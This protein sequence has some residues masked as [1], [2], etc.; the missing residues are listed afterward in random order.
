MANSVYAFKKLT[1]GVDDSYLDYH[2]GSD[3]VHGD[4]AFGIVNGK[5]YAYWLEDESYMSENSPN[6]IAPDVGDNG[7][8]WVLASEYVQ[9]ESQG[10]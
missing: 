8:R 1:G 9:Y 2:E 6:I 3:L 4:M 7:K 5:F 10:V